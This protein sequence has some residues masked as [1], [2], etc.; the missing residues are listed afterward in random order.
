MII[1]YLLTWRNRIWTEINKSGRNDNS[2]F[3][4]RGSATWYCSALLRQKG[5]MF[6]FHVIL[7]KQQK[8]LPANEMRVW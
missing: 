6:V 1:N 5:G 8:G 2:F 7:A 3:G 4:E